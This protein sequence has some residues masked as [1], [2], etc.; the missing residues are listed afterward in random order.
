MP[1]SNCKTTIVDYGELILGTDED[2]KRI[3]EQEFY[4]HLYWYYGRWY[5]PWWDKKNPEK[6]RR[7]Q[8]EWEKR[9]REVL[10]TNKLKWAR[11]NP[12]KV[13]ASSEK[14]R[15]SPKGKALRRGWN[16]PNGLNR[17]WKEKYKTIC[18]VPPQ[19]KWTQE[20]IDLIGSGSITEVALMLGRSY[21]SVAR[22]RDK[23]RGGK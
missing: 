4:Q 9:N 8:R 10:T 12:E 23:L 17:K 19:K 14:Y 20:D 21:C 2:A 13:K 18:G 3:A 16:G 1:A 15:R 7:F 5:G 22:K 6:R 11:E